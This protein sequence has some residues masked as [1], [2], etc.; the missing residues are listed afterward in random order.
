MTGHCRGESRVLHPRL[1]GH[2][3]PE[4]RGQQWLLLEGK[5]IMKGIAQAVTGIDVPARPG[6]VPGALKEFWRARV[7]ISERPDDCLGFARGFCEGALSFWNEAKNR[8]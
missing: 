1:G 7:G 3:L 4:L 2:F 6:P 8:I 5:A